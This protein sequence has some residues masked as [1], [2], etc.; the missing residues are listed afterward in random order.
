MCS[1]IGIGAPLPAARPAPR[2]HLGGGSRASPPQ[3]APGPGRVGPGLANPATYQ[4]GGTDWA[5][6]RT[7]FDQAS[8]EVERLYARWEALQALKSGG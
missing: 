2:L 5:A 1:S 3:T 7:G 4:R 8:A 6:L